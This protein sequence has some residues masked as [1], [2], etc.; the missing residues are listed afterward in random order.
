METQLMSLTPYENFLYGM[1]A[2][3]TKRQYPHRLDKFLTFMNLQG[4]IEEKCAK[5]YQMANENVNLFQA[6]IIRFINFQKERIEIKEIS[7]GTL[8]NYV[9][10]IKLFC[11]MNDI[12]INWKKIGKG[13]PSEKHNA[14]DR[15]PTVEEIHKLLEY[16]DRRLKPIVHVMIS[17]G[18]RVGSWDFLKWQHVIPIND[19]ESDSVLAARINVRNTKINNREYYSFITP[20]AY[21]SLRDWMDFRQLHGEDINGDSWLMRDIWQKTDKAHGHRIGLAKYPRKLTSSAIK[22]LIYEAWKVQGIR[23]KLSNPEKKRHEFK[24]T[25]GFRKYF[26]TKCQMAKMNHNNIKLLM[27]HSLGESQNYHR[28]TEEELLD[29]YLCAI[30]KL[31]INEENRL[32]KRLS[33]YEGRDDAYSLQI[34][35]K[36][37]NRLREKGLTI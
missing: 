16:P 35:E 11:N 30:D 25:H 6:N 7:E 22:N 10:A 8:C 1:K 23:D 32:K 19:R 14:D 2:K 20:E 3:E 29:D 9:K 33:D 31:T 28:P 13:L 36:I 37:L 5:L 17:A 26:E 27:D 4:K 34:T 18:I 21:Y 12:M 24:S 15:I